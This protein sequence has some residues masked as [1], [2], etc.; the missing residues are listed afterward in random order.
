MPLTKHCI[1][2][3]VPGL[4]ADDVSVLQ[5]QGGVLLAGAA[6]LCGRAHDL[7]LQVHKMQ[8]AVEGVTVFLPYAYVK[9][10]YLSVV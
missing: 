1:D 9:Y 2:T 3:L 4:F 8:A 10:R 6:T 5:Q 7:L